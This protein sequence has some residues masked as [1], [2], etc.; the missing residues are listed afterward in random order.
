MYAGLHVKYAVFLPDFNET[1]FSRQIFVQ[2]SNI[3]FM[4][5]RPVG[6]QMFQA[7][8]HTSR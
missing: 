7:A 2:Y 5:N 4:D 8:G 1:F 3:N 6:A